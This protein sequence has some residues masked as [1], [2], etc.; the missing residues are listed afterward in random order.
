ME[1]LPDRAAA[2]KR[3]SAIKALSHSKKEK[4]I[5]KKG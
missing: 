3:E 2:L 5:G 4:L 1:K